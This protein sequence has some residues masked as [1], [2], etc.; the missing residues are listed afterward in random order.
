MTIAIADHERCYVMT[1]D[2]ETTY[3]NAKMIDDKPVFMGVGPLV[4]AILA[5]I[6]AK[7]EKYL[8]NKGA[9]IVKVSHGIHR[10]ILR[11]KQFGYEES[12]RSLHHSG[13]RSDILSIFKVETCHEKLYGGRT[14]RDFRCAPAEN[15]VS[16]KL[17]NIARSLTSS[18][19]GG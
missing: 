14:G 6:D 11:Y 13:Q 5:Q 19:L 18:Y 1:M 8:D 4:T 7:F 15:L 17:R 2:V 16:S 9:V 3:L 12:H 10:C